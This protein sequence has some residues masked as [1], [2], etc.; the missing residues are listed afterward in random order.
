MPAFHPF[1]ETGLE[2]LEAQMDSGAGQLLLRQYQ[3]LVLLE[4]PLLQQQIHA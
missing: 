2:R 4:Q 1:L 3:P